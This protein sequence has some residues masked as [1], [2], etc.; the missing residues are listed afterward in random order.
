MNYVSYV[1][2][3]LR[4]II[5]RA[6]RL[7][8]YG[9]NIAAGSSISGL[10]RGIQSAGSRLVINT[11]NS[12]NTLVGAGFGM[13]MNEVDCI[14]FMKQQDFLLLAVDQLVNT[15]NLVR[16]RPARAS[17][18]IVNVTVDSG[19]EGPQSC[20]NNF[21]D[22]CS[23]ARIQGY[24]IS[25]RQE[26]DAVLS[27]HLISPGFRIISVSQRLFRTEMIDWEGPVETY[28]EGAVTRYADG[29]DV[30]IVC[31]NFSAPQGIELWKSF[32]QRGVDAALFSI[33]AVLPTDWQPVLDSVCRTGQIVILDDSK[34]VNRT[35]HR[36]ALQ[37]LQKNPTVKVF[38]LSRQMDDADLAPNADRYE[39]DPTL[40]IKSLESE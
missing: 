25:T 13:M 16:I 5:E 38:D 9:Q 30:T 8:V 14:Y 1:N 32:R 26:A 39:V 11:P 37:V 22:F 2:A 19:Y 31:F 7:V 4:E 18:T 36:L 24:T 35:S 29:G 23:I 34:S 20:L 10:T 12:E 21:S 3:Q 33:S 28:E 40:V 15:Y 27:A 6:D 17:F